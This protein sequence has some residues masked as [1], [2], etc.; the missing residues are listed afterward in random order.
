MHL[1]YYEVMHHSTKAENPIKDYY[2]KCIFS[3]L[4][5]K[6]PIVGRKSL[7]AHMIGRSGHGS[8]RG[9]YFLILNVMLVHEST[10]QTYKGNHIYYIN[11]CSEHQN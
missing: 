9:V 8:C 5:S 6:Q 7:N 10:I 1:T 2:L 11:L 3:R 4:L